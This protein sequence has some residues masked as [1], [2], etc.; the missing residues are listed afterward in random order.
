MIVFIVA[1]FFYLIGNRIIGFNERIHK[2]YNWKNLRYVMFLFYFNYF[3][4]RNFVT[5]YRN[6]NNICENIFL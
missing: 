2:S 6:S 3:I 5:L 4:C 1:I